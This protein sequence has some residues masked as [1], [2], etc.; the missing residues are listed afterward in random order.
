M[1]GGRVTTPSVAHALS[2]P[3]SQA[4]AALAAL[5]KAGYVSVETHPLS[6]VVVYVFPDI[7]AGFVAPT[8]LPEDRVSAVPAIATIPA[9]PVNASLALVR[10]SSKSRLTAALLAFCGGAVGAH[11]F[12]LQ[13][14]ALGVLYLLMFWTFLPA[15]AGFF[16]GVGYLFMSEHAFDIK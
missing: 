16:E 11:K 12:Y 2:L 6:N 10:V 4:D 8:M 13:E 9:V 7:D 3:L 15:I 5:A 14:R 1:S